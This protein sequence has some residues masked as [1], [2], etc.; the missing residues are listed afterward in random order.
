MVTEYAYKM[1]L[2]QM[3]QILAYTV[4]PMPE[5]DPRSDVNKGYL[6]GTSYLVKLEASSSPGSAASFMSFKGPDR[7]KDGSTNRCNTATDYGLAD[8]RPVH[9]TTP[10]ACSCQYTTSFGIPCRH[11]LAV[12]FHYPDAVT[13]N[14]DML[15]HLRWINAYEEE[16]LC[17]PIE[18]QH[19]SQNK[20]PTVCYR[21]LKEQQCD[22]FGFT[23]YFPSDL[24]NFNIQAYIGEYLAFKYGN[25]NQGAWYIAKICKSTVVN[26]PNVV[27]LT[28]PFDPRHGAAEAWVCCCSK[29]V[30]E[31][32]LQY[33][34]QQPKHS[35]V[36]LKPVEPQKPDGVQILNPPAQKA[37]R[38]QVHRKRPAAGGPLA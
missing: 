7:H 9:W 30:K 28:W 17:V 23:W 24:T 19:D 35:W 16:T 15:F 27:R 32:E 3:S 6:P 10:K 37:G 1:L 12:R 38:P 34:R 2:G 21:H 5:S 20:E 4:Q 29:A 31:H 11:I 8:M 18:G 36:L 22:K 13:T 33:W 25:P 26:Q 14:L